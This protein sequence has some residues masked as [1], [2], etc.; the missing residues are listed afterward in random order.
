MAQSLR[1]AQMILLHIAGIQ[2]DII[3]CRCG[4]LSLGT[5]TLF[6]GE[7]LTFSVQVIIIMLSI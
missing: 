4:N 2:P 6:N 1:P 3:I 7:R 5:P